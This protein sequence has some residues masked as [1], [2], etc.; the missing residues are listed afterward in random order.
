MFSLRATKRPHKVVVRYWSQSIGKS[1]VLKYGMSMSWTVC[2][3]KYLSWLIL[4]HQ[5]PAGRCNKCPFKALKP[6]ILMNEKG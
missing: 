3:W 5:M 6:T 2:D 4:L 1:K